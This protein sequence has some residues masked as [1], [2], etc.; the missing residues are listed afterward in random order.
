MGESWQ[1]S[2]LY[3]ALLV[4]AEKLQRVES[5]FLSENDFSTDKRASENNE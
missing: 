5:R 3:K 2:L 4:A 1:V